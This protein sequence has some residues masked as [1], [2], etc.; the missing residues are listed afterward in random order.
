MNDANDTRVKAYVH[1][2]RAA[3]TAHSQV[4]E[5]LLDE[6]LTATQFSTLKVLKMN[7]PLPQREIA[8]R[9]LKS[10]G[11]ITYVVDHLEKAGLVVRVRD[12]KDRRLYSVQLTDAGNTFFDRYYPSHLNNIVSTMQTLT[13]DECAQ[14]V[15]ILA[16]L[17]SDGSDI[18]PTS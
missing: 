2:V 13:D 5:A 12:A 18:C 9:I 1:L 3:E 4:S 11:N 16:K 15:S 8:Q 14:L 6:R 7:G 10:E 17:S